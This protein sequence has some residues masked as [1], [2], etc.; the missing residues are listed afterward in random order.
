MVRDPLRVLVIAPTPFFGDRGCHVRI[1]EEVRGL[2]A[3]GIEVRVVTYPTG[4][5]LD[6]IETVRARDWFGVKAAALGPTRGRPLLDL[7]VLDACRRVMRD[8]R[9]HLIHGHLHEGIAIGAALRAWYGMPLIADLQGS[10]TE[11]L[12][13]HGFIAGRGMLRRLTSCGERWLVRRPDRLVTSSAHGAALL[14]RQGGDEDRIVPLPDGVDVGVFR[15]GQPDVELAHRL[16]LDRKR[17]IVFLGVLTEYQGVDL[18]LDA[19]PAVIHQRPDAHFLVMGFPNEAHYRHL[20]AARGIE[21]AVTFTGRVP[22]EQAPRWIN[23]GEIAVSPKRSLTEANGKLLNYMA[24]GRPVV[25]SDTPVNREMLGEAGVYVAVGD[26]AALAAR[27]VEMLVDP[28][29]ARARGAALRVRAEEEFAWPVLIERLEA[30]YLSVLEQPGRRK[31]AHS[32][33]AREHRSRK[34]MP[35]PRR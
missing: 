32:L 14:A 6:G 26:A 12:T 3:R 10:L 34:R 4:R 13:D 19:V 20:A 27:L 31:I 29:E 15:P 35:V 16:G 7:A 30:L 1:Y 9:P 21:R 17:I 2:M 11:E 8:F 28:G 5:D 25:A 24:C 18:L 33:N 22:Y 23:L